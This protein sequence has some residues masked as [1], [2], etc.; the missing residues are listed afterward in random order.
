MNT[1]FKYMISWLEVELELFFM[2]LKIKLYY[3]ERLNPRDEKKI[4]K[5]TTSKGSCNFMEITEFLML[6]TL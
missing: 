6:S 4:L 2:A 3:G 5:G 1:A